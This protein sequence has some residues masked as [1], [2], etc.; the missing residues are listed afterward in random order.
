METI[1]SAKNEQLKHLSKL[2]S[3]AKARRLHK[4]TVL[5]GVHLLQAYLQAGGMPIRVYIPE[6]KRQTPEISALL[7]KL[8]ENQ[9]IPVASGILAKISGLTDAEEILTLIDIPTAPPLPEHGDCVVLD[10]VQDPGNVGTVMRSTAAAGIKQLILSND[11]ADA[12]SPKVLRAGMGAHFLLTICERVDLSAWCPSYQNPIWA[13]ALSQHNEHHLYDMTLTEPAAWV[14]GNEGS[15]I[16]PDILD[17]V[18]GCV[19]IPMAGQTESLNV[20]MAA[21]V[22]LFEQLRQRLP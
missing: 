19:R 20:A 21:T 15:G 18:D 5:E 17:K 22:C 12:W 10:R 1:T 9:Q 4:Q 11:C 3:Q 8:S 16:R 2:L 13:T 6:H 14:F 7:A